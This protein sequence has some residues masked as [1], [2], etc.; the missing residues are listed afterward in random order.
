M[1]QNIAVDTVAIYSGGNPPSDQQ[2]LDDSSD[3]DTSLL[4]EIIRPRQLDPS[5]AAVQAAAETTTTSPLFH[6]ADRLVTTVHDQDW[7]T[8][9]NPHTSINGPVCSR[10]WAVRNALGEPLILNNAAGF[11]TMSRLDFVLLMFP[12]TQLAGGYGSFDKR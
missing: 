10:Q 6:T 7:Y 3:S 9:R 12:P 1:I 2:A 8:A 5:A 11:S 4:C